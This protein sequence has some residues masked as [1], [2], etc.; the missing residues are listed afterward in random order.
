[1]T[2]AEPTP[3]RRPRADQARL[4][5]DVLRHQIHAGGYPDGLPSEGELATEFFVS[6][7]T[8]REALAALK[9]EGL[10]GRG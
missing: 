8:V 4:V 9:T 3:I 6:R 1:M 10:I 5:A 7:N 2:H